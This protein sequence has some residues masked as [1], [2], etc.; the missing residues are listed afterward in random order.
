MKNTISSR[1]AA[2]ILISLTCSPGTAD[3][4]RAQLI[5]LDQRTDGVLGLGIGR[6]ASI[7][8]DGDGVEEIVLGG[9]TG[10]AGGPF[11]SD[12]ALT[13]VRKASDGQFDVT[14]R[15]V[16]TDITGL[17]RG[18]FRVMPWTID[19]APHIVTFGANRMV[20][21]YDADLR[22]VRNFSI[23]G[24]TRDADPSVIGLDD[25][26][27]AIGDIDAD[28]SDELV[29]GGRISLNAFSMT[30]G[31]RRWSLPIAGISDVALS[32]LD[33]DPALEII[34]AGESLALILDGAT[35][36][37]DWS[38]VDG[39]GQMIMPG[40]FGASGALGWAASSHGAFT[41][42]QSAPYS[43]VWNGGQG[44]TNRLLAPLSRGIGGRDDILASDGLHVYL[45]DS[46]THAERF[47]I[48]V[49]PDPSWPNV[50]SL[51]GHDFDADATDE[52]FFSTGASWNSPSILTIADA[53][54]GA[55][56][57]QWRGAG[58]PHLATAFGDIDGDGR[59][60]LVAATE[61][62]QQQLGTLSVF[63]ASTGRLKWRNPMDWPDATQPFVLSASRIQLRPRTESTGM[64]IVLAGNEYEGGRILVVDGTTFE[65]KLRLEEPALDEVA[66]FV[67]LDYDGDGV[68]DFAV[69]S[70]TYS[71]TS[72]VSV[73]SGVDGSQLWRSP[74]MSGRA[75][76]ILV[77]DKK[78][79]TELIAVLDDGI[80]AY[81]R[82][83]G[84][85]D[86]WLT[87]DTTAGAVYVENGAQGAEIAALSATG[88]I[89]FHDAESRAL[90]RTH[91]LPPPI[92]T[93]TAV[94][95]DVRTLLVASGERLVLI[96]GTT[97]DHLAESAPMSPFRLQGAHLSLR[98]ESGDTWTVASGTHPVLY[99]H[100][101][102][103]G[104]YLFIDGFDSR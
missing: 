101:L 99:R 21:I 27:A 6:T 83:T 10:S 100:R 57:W 71:Y 96:D 53:S 84:L 104:D 4:R 80:R 5:E 2:I 22:E 43:P 59:D 76:Q 19:G 37:T 82:V 89:A 77:V 20:R 11:G 98:R 44:L 55:I 28:G 90:L 94:D 32:Q 79:R 62:P 17:W 41:I 7:D 33:A 40:R 63:D 9:T 54:T 67:L 56:R 65:P 68:E 50:S 69:V 3:T 93:A 35:L 61:Q 97:G 60:E 16:E 75:R 47:R 25:E 58:G 66:D 103:L 23:A 29:V 1:A 14:S 70:N 64:D 31:Q 81:D 78:Q 52:I 73:F 91:V 13:I 24:E 45:Y 74:A 51:V 38:Y 72:T 49:G 87:A 48:P 12:S 85:L 95:G 92:R 18:F 42:F 39:F 15:L 34:V 36:A 102:V 86:W 8:L 88:A 46:A 30:T 26:V